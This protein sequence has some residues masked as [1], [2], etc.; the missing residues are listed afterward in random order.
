MYIDIQES[1]FLKLGLCL[2]CQN[3]LKL[4]HHRFN[5][6]GRYFVPVLLRTKYARFVNLHIIC[7]KVNFTGQIDFLDIL[8]CYVNNGFEN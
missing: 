3:H 2:N 5:F 7:K 4:R 8:T 1:L 6:Q